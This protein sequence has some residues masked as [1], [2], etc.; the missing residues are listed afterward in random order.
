VQLV[1]KRARIADKG[2]GFKTV[3][4]EK[5]W[6]GTYHTPINA[7]VHHDFYKVVLAVE[8][9]IFTSVDV[10]TCTPP[11]GKKKTHKLKLNFG[12][13]ELPE[14]MF[15]AVRFSQLWTRH[16]QD[17]ERY[18][19]RGVA[20]ETVKAMVAALVR[21]HCQPLQKHIAKN[22]A[23]RPLTLPRDVLRL[24]LS[25]ASLPWLR[26]VVC[27]HPCLQ[28]LRTAGAQAAVGKRRSMCRRAPQTRPSA[29]AAAGAA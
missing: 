13:D 8:G 21:L 4:K 29:A 17:A 9:C 23:A 7:A 16:K 19:F 11:L 3:L 26:A 6:L 20:P 12:I 25:A 14:L 24:H 15:K 1:W 27:V 5:V 28:Y 2:A 22:D 10:L 18:V